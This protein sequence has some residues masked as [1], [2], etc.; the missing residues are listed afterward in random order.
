MSSKKL[1]KNRRT[2]THDFSSKNFSWTTILS[3]FLY[4]YSWTT[5]HRRKKAS[6]TACNA[7]LRCPVGVQLVSTVSSKKLCCA[8]QRRLRGGHGVQQNSEIV[9]LVS[10]VSSKTST[11]LSR[12]VHHLHARQ[13]VGIHHVHGVQL[14]SSMSGQAKI[15][16]QKTLQTRSQRTTRHDPGGCVKCEKSVR[17]L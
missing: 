5:G 10:T 7:H 3:C 6:K 17:S 15:H 11:D 12:V 16:A 13:H 1:M 2:D 9:Q 8:V 14:V 4:L